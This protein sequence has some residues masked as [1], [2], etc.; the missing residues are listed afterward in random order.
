MPFRLNCRNVFLTYPRC[1]IEPKQLG[2]FLQHL[3]PAIYIHVVREQ[4]E[5]GTPHLHCL[6]QWVDKYNLRDERKFDFNGHHPNIQPARDVAAIDDYISKHIGPDTPPT[7]SWK[8]GEF[9]N[10]I[11]A[12]KWRKVAEAI[13]EEDVLAAALDA[14]PRDYVIHNDRIREYAR[15]KSRTRLPYRPQPGQT[16][17]LPSSLATYM[18]SEFTNPV[19]L[20]PWILKERHVFTDNQHRTVL[21]PYCSSE[22]HDWEKLRGLD[23]SDTIITGGVCPICPPSIHQQA[24]S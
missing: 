15:S 6:L 8:F 1:P 22:V 21:E 4:H 10:S 16:F 14:S 23:P 7:H 5:D 13:T 20:C 3:R 12:A 24:T 11:A 9:S 19:G 2:E 18:I 17:Q